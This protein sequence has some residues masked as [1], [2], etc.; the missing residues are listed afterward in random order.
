MFTEA[1][2][3]LTRKEEHHKLVLLFSMPDGRWQQ[4]VRSDVG[5]DDACQ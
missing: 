2:P 1:Q 3:Q 4:P 5:I